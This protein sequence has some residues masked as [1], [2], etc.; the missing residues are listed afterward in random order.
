MTSLIISN[1][2]SRTIYFTIPVHIAIIISI[3]PKIAVSFSC[4]V[5]ALLVIIYIS[6]K[7]F[8]TGW[9]YSR[10]FSCWRFGWR[11][12]SALERIQWRW[13]GASSNIFI[14]HHCCLYCDCSGSILNRLRFR[15]VSYYTNFSV[16]YSCYNID[17]WDKI[18]RKFL[19]RGYFAWE[20]AAT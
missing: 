4:V 7:A 14:V 12:E 17:Y 6:C 18:W 9:V 2:V 19:M 5:R 13:G 3:G 16:W 15:N 11:S 10:V 20:S 8:I 1:A